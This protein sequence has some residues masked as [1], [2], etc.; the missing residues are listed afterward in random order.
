MTKGREYAENIVGPLDRSFYNTQRDVSEKTYQTNWE[1]LQNQYKNLQEK[2]KRDQAEANRAFANGLVNV[3]EN[4]YDRMKKANESMALKG[5]TSSGLNNLVEQGDI[6]TKGAEVLDLLEKSGDVSVSVAE[7]LNEMNK[8][9]TEKQNELANSLADTLG[10]IGASDTSAQMAYNKGLA[11]IA[12]EMEAREAENKLAAAQ[13]A[14]SAASSGYNTNDL[15][16]AL[17]EAQKRSLI[18]QTLFSEDLSESQKKA[19]LSALF[20]Y[21]RPTA[22]LAYQFTK[23]S[24]A[25]IYLNDINRL[26][27]ILYGDK[28]S[29]DLLA[30]YNFNYNAKKGN[31][32]N[33]KKKIY[34]G[35]PKPFIPNSGILPDDNSDFYL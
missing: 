31:E 16:E 13:R 25:G 35:T 21:D 33:N 10:N 3:A 17:S 28:M 19:T 7:D 27:E 18:M 1:N 34:Y 20:G 2:L 23:P 11:G 30:L 24:D 29:D 12:E 26:Q 6:T 8:T 32:S 14:A 9:A 15:D 5:L 22:E 4:S